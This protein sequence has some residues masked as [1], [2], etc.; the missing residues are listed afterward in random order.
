M[1]LLILGGTKFLGRHLVEVA[2]AGGHEVTLF[3][4]G[5]NN[6]DLFP[7]VEKLR[8]DRDGGLDALRGRRWD[9]VVDTSGYVPRVVRA[10]AEMLAESVGMYVFIS[11]M[12][13]YA[14]FGQPN[15]EDSPVGTLEDENVEEITGETYGP[16]KALCEQAAEA[17]MPGRVLNVRAG[18]I[19]GPFDP[20]SRFPYWTARAARGGEVL[21]P[22][23]PDRQVQLIDARDLSEWILRMLAEGRAGVFN[24]CGPV[25]RLTMQGFLEACRDASASDARFTWAGEQFLLDA[26]VEPWSELPLWLPESAEKHRYFLASN[27]DKAFAAGLAFRPLAETARDTLAWQKAGTPAPVK[28][29]VQIADETMKPERERELLKAWHDRED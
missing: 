15:D 19:V 6:P 20:T 21:A 26:G 12:S 28:D 25:Y 4:R 22:A 14:D 27:C 9:A 29:G 11:S 24:A 5:Q 10:S 7:E 3:N 13:V 16:L 1:K 2:L 18:L 23:P 8:G 17:T